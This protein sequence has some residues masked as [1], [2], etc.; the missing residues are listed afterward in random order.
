MLPF[1]LIAGQDIIMP[2]MGIIPHDHARQVNKAATRQLA[3]S[4]LFPTES[5][6]SSYRSQLV[7][8]DFIE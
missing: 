6:I 8:V 7:P 2:G 5:K 4:F 3:T 1:R